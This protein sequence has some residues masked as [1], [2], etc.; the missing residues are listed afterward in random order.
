MR[1]EYGKLIYI[2][3]DSVSEEAQELVGFNLVKP[4]KTVYSL[5]NTHECLSLLQDPNILIAT[6]GKP[7]PTFPL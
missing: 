1:T 4:I 5:L 6:R 2:L 7:I 3:Q